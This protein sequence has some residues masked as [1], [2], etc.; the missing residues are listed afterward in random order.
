VLVV[1]VYKLVERG[2]ESQVSGVVKANAGV[3]GGVRRVQLEPA[4][5]LPLQ[6]PWTPPFIAARMETRCTGV[7]TLLLRS[8]ETCLNP[9][10]AWPAGLPCYYRLC[11]RRGC[12][13]LVVLVMTMDDVGDANAACRE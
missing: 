9:V 7:D 2:S 6:G 8:E 13:V 4:Q 11:Q 3:E 12:G 10:A 5:P 1:G